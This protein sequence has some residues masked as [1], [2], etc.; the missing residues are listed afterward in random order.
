M[1]ISY[2]S[3]NI[4][5]IKYA[6]QNLFSL[7]RFCKTSSFRLTFFRSPH[8]LWLFS[9]ND[10]IKNLLVVNNIR[11]TIPLSKSFYK[12]KILTVFFGTSRIS[13]KVVIDVVNFCSNI[14]PVLTN[15]LNL[16]RAGFNKKKEKPRVLRS[17]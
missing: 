4:I 5:D 6:S 7:I 9:R 12:I 16:L 3:I 2:V 11:Y 17:M 1:K 8:R 13:L 14:S 15:I 10:K